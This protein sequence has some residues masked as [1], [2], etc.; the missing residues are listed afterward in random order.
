MLITLVYDV[1]TDTAKM[2]IGTYIKVT[3]TKQA[4]RQYSVVK[5][6]NQKLST[7]KAVITIILQD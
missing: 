1:I 5:I 2:S 6:T 7:I 3:L 4:D